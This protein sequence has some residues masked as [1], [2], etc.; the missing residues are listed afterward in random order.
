[1][2]A[3]SLT[4]IAK[5]FSVILCLTFN[6]FSFIFN[7]KIPTIEEQQSILLLASFIALVFLPVDFSILIKNFFKF[8]TGIDLEDKK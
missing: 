5:I 7:K 3:K 6:V 1:M 2:Q 8:K 4:L